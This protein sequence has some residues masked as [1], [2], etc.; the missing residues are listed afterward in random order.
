MFMFMLLFSSLLSFLLLQK[1]SSLTW[2]W[3]LFTVTKWLINYYLFKIGWVVLLLLRS[4][5]FW[6]YEVIFLII[7]RLLWLYLKI[8]IILIDLFV[9]IWKKI[10]AMRT[11]SRWFSIS[12]WGKLWHHHLV[13]EL[14]SQ[15]WI[16]LFLVSL[17]MFLF[18]PLIFRYFLFIFLIK[19]LL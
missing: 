16:V 10:S 1:S 18:K 7:L 3:K 8:I 17:Q 4:V 2:F 19:S 5:I 13:L 15:M 6:K 12:F 14:L 11:W 9:C